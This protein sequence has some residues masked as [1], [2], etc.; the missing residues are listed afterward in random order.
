MLEG[1]DV[2]YLE[3]LSLQFR[4][5]SCKSFH[6]MLRWARD[7]AGE[8]WMLW[9]WN[10]RN[11][12]ICEYIEIIPGSTDPMEAGIITPQYR[13]SMHLTVRSWLLDKTQT[14]PKPRFCSSYATLYTPL[15]WAALSMSLKLLITLCLLAST[16]FSS[17]V[18]VRS[19][20]AVKERHHVPRKFKRIGPAP[21]QH[22]IRLQ[23]GLKQSQFAELERH[24]YE[25][26]HEKL[27]LVNAFP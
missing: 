11:F 25:G 20:Y 21:S 23:I 17:E 27:R 8:E 7:G 9:L 1:M 2:A 5:V 22:K 26:S 19:N 16:V 14:Y 4:V 24:L 3:C 10:L 13:N 6:A 12:C 18:R 15:L